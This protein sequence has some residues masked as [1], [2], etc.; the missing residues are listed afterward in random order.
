MA[1][2][3]FSQ[4][5][6]PTDF[7]AGKWEISVVG[8]PVG[9]VKFTTNLVRKAGKLTGELTNTTDPSQAKRPLIRVEE[10]GDKLMMYFESSQ[11]GEVPIDLTK[12]D[13]D[14]LKGTLSTFDAAAKRVKP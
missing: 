6:T 3:G 14:N 13:D 1:H 4:T 10:K 7:F 11:V 12:V 8:S 2:A 9:D 5:A